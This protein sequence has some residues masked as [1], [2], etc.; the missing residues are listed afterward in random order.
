MFT[1]PDGLSWFDAMRELYAI[2]QLGGFAPEPTPI[3]VQQPTDGA[4]E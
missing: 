2:S 3:P 4:G 1:K